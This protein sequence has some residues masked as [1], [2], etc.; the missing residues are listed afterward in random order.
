MRNDLLRGKT[1]AIMP[2][3]EHTRAR[4]AKSSAILLRSAVVF[5]AVTLLAAPANAALWKWID[6]NGRV[7]YSDIPPTGDIKAERINSASPPSNP[8]AVKEMVNQEADLKKRQTQ[9][10]EDAAKLEKAKADST[11]RQEQCAQMRGQLKALQ[12]DS[13]QI[14]RINERGERV[15][16]DPATRQKE[17]E[18][19]ETSLRDQC[20]A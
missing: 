13:L 19:L 3:R 18:R 11:R 9:R 1:P 10:A 2:R 6:A 8:N 17:R 16:M 20:P 14:Y 5:F 7:V 15:L 4:D 12:T